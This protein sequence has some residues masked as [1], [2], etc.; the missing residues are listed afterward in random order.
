MR[1]VFEKSITYKVL[2]RIERLSGS[3]ILRSDIADIAGSRQISRSL[4]RLVQCG[5]LAKLGYG[6]YA[7]LDY[8]QI[9]KT[10]YLKDG[11]LPTMRLALTKLNILWEPSPEE[12][13]Y[14]EG[15]STQIPVNPS[16]KIKDRFRR[17]LRYRDTALRRA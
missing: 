2:K 11:V 16:T 10:S 12:Q 5:R 9:S 6:V 8:S 14:Q 17:Q 1:V 15:R 7:K 13:A 4:N 3:V